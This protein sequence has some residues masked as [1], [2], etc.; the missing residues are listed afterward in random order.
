MTSHTA[1]VRRNAV[2][3]QPA[4]LKFPTRARQFSGGRSGSQVTAD[5]RFRFDEVQRGIASVVQIIVPL[6]NFSGRT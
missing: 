1:L 2:R 4:I 3:C 5:C 6:S